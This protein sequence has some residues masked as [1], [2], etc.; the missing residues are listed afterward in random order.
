[1]KHD[2]ER[3]YVVASANNAEDDG[4]I[5]MMLSY[6]NNQRETLK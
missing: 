3:S 4:K 1:M 5:L 6:D 2:L